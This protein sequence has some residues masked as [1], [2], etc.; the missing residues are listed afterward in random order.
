MYQIFCKVTTVMKVLREAIES[1][2]ARGR[3]K[4]NKKIT[5]HVRERFFLTDKVYLGY[6]VSLMAIK[7]CINSLPVNIVSPPA[8]ANSRL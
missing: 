3:E 8:V 6:F 7:Y 2:L 1:Q 4:L 5:V